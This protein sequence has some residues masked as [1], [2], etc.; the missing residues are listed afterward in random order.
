MFG[1]DG[2]VV[3]ITRSAAGRGR[4]MAQL[5]AV[6]PVSEEDTNALPVKDLGPAIAFYE[7]VLGFS[8]AGRDAPPAV[9]TRDG[10]R[11]GLVQK[12]GHE[13]ER[14]GSLAFEVDDL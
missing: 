7:S 6:Y 10:V 2:S 8:A 3:L 14:A 1:D 5:K 9:L 13:P 11:I 12:G 4:A